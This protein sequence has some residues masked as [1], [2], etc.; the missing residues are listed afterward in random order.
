MR[1]SPAAARVL[2]VDACRSGGLTAVKG[3]KQVAPFRMEVENEL[4]AEGTA[5]LSSSAAGEDSQESESLEASVFTHYFASALLGA[6]DANGDGQVTLSESFSY[7]SERT[8]AST[9]ST[10]AGPQH[11]SYRFDIGGRGDLVLTRPLRARHKLGTLAFLEPGSYFVR[12]GNMGGPLVAEV[13]N[14]VGLRYLAV[15][16]GRYTVTARFPR[17]LLEGEV[18]VTESVSSAVR[19][20][21]MKRL[22]Y[23][24]VVRKGGTSRQSA[25]SVFASLG[26]QSAVL[27]LGAQTRG[28]LGARVDFTA[29]SVELELRYGASETVNRA[30]ELHSGQ[31]ALSTSVLRAFDLGPLTFSVGLEVGGVAMRQSF[32]DGRN[33]VQRAVGGELGP[34]ATLEI[35]MGPRFYFRA[36][37]EAPTLLI[38]RAD[39]E[40]ATPFSVSVR[41]GL[42]VYF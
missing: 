40:L 18:T 28:A 24:H 11:P 27:G 6:G 38:P 9:L 23:A 2:V 30:V 22:D 7:A 21:Q 35:P 42:G 25:A 37:A 26:V 17:Y 39:H 20:V 4:S 33:P 3:G 1:S 19:A 36:R 5:F 34:L 32:P 31:L 15:P 12:R 14:E 16:A 29:L 13:L 10:F 8:T 41:G